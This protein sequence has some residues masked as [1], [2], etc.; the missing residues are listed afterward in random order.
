MLSFSFVKGYRVL[1]QTEYG[2]NFIKK[3]LKKLPDLPAMYANSQFY[4]LAAWSKWL[5]IHGG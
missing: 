5:L 3:N 1:K 2:K 4:I